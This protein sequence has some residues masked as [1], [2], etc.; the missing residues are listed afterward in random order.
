MQADS[1]PGKPADLLSA[2]AKVAAARGWRVRDKSSRR[3]E[4]N[5]NPTM[6]SLGETV[7]VIVENDPSV[8]GSCIVK[9]S[10]TARFQALDF[11]RTGDNVS[12][13]LAGMRE[14]ANGSGPSA[15]PPPAQADA[16]FCANCGA[17]MS[18]NAAYCPS[19][20]EAQG[21]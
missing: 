17:R 5:T 9:V 15:P 11:G 14:I 1:L 12:A 7:K 20:G 4:I 2:A 8:P 10:S 16:K 13:V 21:G 19:C 18:R 6:G 3:L